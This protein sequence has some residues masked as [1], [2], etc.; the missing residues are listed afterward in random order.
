MILPSHFAIRNYVAIVLGSRL[1]LECHTFLDR[2][3]TSRHTVVTFALPD[4]L[5]VATDHMIHTC[6]LLFSNSWSITTHVARGTI[7]VVCELRASKA[8][9]LS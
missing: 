1:Y 9:L 6:P 4:N 7:Y 5:T 2:M 3:T 8:S